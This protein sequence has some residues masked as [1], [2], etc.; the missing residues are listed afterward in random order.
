VHELLRAV[1]PLTDALG[2]QLI[3]RSKLRDGDIELRWEG[4]VVGGVRLPE[5]PRDIEWFLARIEREYDRPLAQL[6]R[7][8]KQRIVKQ[9]NEAGAFAL[10]K[11]VE[12]VAEVLG[13]SR[14]TVYNYLNRPEE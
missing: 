13:V 2:A 9:L 1:K 7:V 3:P 8:E 11:S 5:R 4:E 10:R 14:F 6:D 12:Q